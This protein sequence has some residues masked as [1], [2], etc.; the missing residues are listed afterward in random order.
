MYEKIGR[1][2]V[3]QVDLAQRLDAV[4]GGDKQR[5]VLEPDP[6]TGWHALRV[7]GVPAIEPVWRTITGDCLFNLRSA[8]DHL[9]YQLVRLDNKTPTDSTYFRIRDSPFLD[10]SGKA[11]PM[12][13]DPAI[14]YQDILDAIEKVQPYVDT[15]DPP[16]PSTWN[17]LWELHRLNHRQ[18]PAVTGRRQRPQS[19]CHLLSLERWSRSRTEVPRQLGGDTE[20]RHAGGL[21][22]VPWGRATG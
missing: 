8:L 20:G 10:K 11:V 4:L 17:P 2:K 16:E 15:G 9:A 3:H 6:D 12:Q 22:R 5:F 21:V 18:A 13:F 14:G 19:A 1:A 7:F